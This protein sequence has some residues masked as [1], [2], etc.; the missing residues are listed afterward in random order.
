LAYQIISG[1][2]G[3]KGE[4]LVLSVDGQGRIVLA[5][6]T[7]PTAPQWWSLIYDPTSGNFAMLNVGSIESGTPSVLAAN[8][9]QSLSLVALGDALNQN[10]TWNVAQGGSALAV[11]PGFS[12][13]YNLNVAG[14]GPYGP[15][16]VVIAW[17]G[18]GGGQ[19]NEIWT[20]G[21]LD[22]NYYPWTYAFMPE[23]APSLY[24]TA[25]PEKAGAQLTIAEPNG[26]Q[27]PGLAQQWAC[28][29][30]IEGT[31]PFGAVFI[32]ELIGMAIHTTPGC[33]QLFTVYAGKLDPWSAWIVGPGPDHNSFG[34]RSI[35]DQNL[36]W[37]VSGAGP[38]PPGN[39]VITFPWQGGAQ[40]ELWTLMFIP[41]DVTKPRMSRMRSHGEPSER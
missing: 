18:W 33:G 19:P 6:S 16:S 22:E 21:P 23:C 9:D 36:Y 2:T 26:P 31:K 39:E 12:T 35:A 4:Q 25:N 10:S 24:L 5:D 37:N 28:T 17:D 40:N 13:S 34:I 8:A 30:V 15:G 3:P 32:N 11:R 38:Y 29:Y 14:D 27:G 41:Q 1:T 7:Y 20:F